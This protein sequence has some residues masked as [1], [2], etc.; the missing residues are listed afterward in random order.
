MSNEDVKEVKAATSIGCGL[1]M[2][3][4]AICLGLTW[5]VQG[6]EFFLMKVFA[7]REEALRR[8]TFEQS[9]AYTEG[10]AQDLRRQQLEY[11]KA[12]PDQK[13]AIASVIL[14]EYASIDQTTMPADLR[15]FLNEIK[16]SQG[17]Q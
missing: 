14:H 6:N 7:P 10:M 4:L 5:L 9:K 16:Q 13:Q 17:V 2:L 1:I 3:S 11:I 15:Q 12:T 8:Q